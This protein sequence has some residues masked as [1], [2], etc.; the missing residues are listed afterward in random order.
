MEV[1][2]H[3][4]LFISCM[5]ISVSQDSSEMTI[6]DLDFSGNTCFQ[7][8]QSSLLCGV[9]LPV[10]AGLRLVEKICVGSEFL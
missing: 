3:I 1:M 9:H 7:R 10:S 2:P 6:L 8:S 4:F 5:S